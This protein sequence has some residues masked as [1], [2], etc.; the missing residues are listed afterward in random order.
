MHYGQN[1]FQSGTVS[2]ISTDGMMYFFSAAL[3]TAS[4]FAVL[5]IATHLVAKA[6]VGQFFFWLAIVQ[7]GAG[8]TTLGF[9]SSVLRRSYN[10]IFVNYIA[11][12]G[13]GA[14]LTTWV[15][16]SA[17]GLTTGLL[18]AVVAVTWFARSISMLSEARMLAQGAVRRLSVCYLIYAVTLPSSAVILIVTTAAS[19]ESL[20]L[21]YAL[22]E[23][24]IAL[25]G[26]YPIRGSSIR[27]P[28]A[29]VGG[30]MA[31]IRNSMAYGLPIMVAGI[32][33][34]GL[35]SLDRMI[36]TAFRGYEEV[37]EFSILYTIAFAANRFI[38]APANQRIFPLFVRGRDDK[39][40]LRKVNTMSGGAW[41]I[42]I[43]YCVAVTFLGPLA[44]P[45]FLGDAYSFASWDL[46]LISAASSFFLV[47]TINSA[48]LK[49]RND[50][51]Q[52]MFLLF[53]ALTIN[54]VCSLLLVPVL[55][56]RG[57]SISTCLAYASLFVLVRTRV[58]TEFDT[59]KIACGRAL[60]CTWLGGGGCG[61][62]RIA[63]AG[64]YGH[65]NLGDEAL[66]AAAIKLVNVHTNL[67]AENIVILSDDAD[68]TRTRIPANIEVR[69]LKRPLS[70]RFWRLPLVLWDIF[71]ALR[72]CEELVFGGG[73][74]LNDS[75]RSSLPLY[76]IINMLARLRR[77]RV[78][79][80]SI[81]LGPLEDS[82]YRR[83][84]RAI[85]SMSDFV[86][87]RDN[88]SSGL[89]QTLTGQSP[90]LAPDLAHALREERQTQPRT[91]M[92]IGMSIIPYCKPGLWFDKDVVKYRRYINTMSELITG[93]LEYD[94]ELT[95][96][97]MP[98]SLRQDRPAIAD[99]IRTLG[100]DAAKR[101]E[102]CECGSVEE[103]LQE[104]SRCTLIIATRLH[105]A[106]LATIAAT[107]IVAIA[108]QSKVSSYVS[109]LGLGYDC[110]DISS[111][112]SGD[113]LSSISDS[114]KHRQ[115]L[116]GK[117]RALN[118]IRYSKLGK[119]I[120]D[121]RQGR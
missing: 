58:S 76:I 54:V 30:A 49:V 119:M 111:V 96:S 8:I 10:R 71:H 37:A 108:Y 121:W 25:A 44:L 36:V 98:V 103:F 65:G 68:D 114:L 23:L 3:K 20:L 27:L 47:F 69:Q 41:L 28:R 57:A 48:Y 60:P 13:F 120:G 85:L 110:F 115:E 73:G 1:P 81:G 62:L 18:T 40:Q 51:K 22:S 33:N 15:V 26:I 75:N 39:E 34:L 104:S 7:F 106:V 101:V 117:I 31:G 56:Y 100:T 11:G 83:M 16:T 87:V 90:I 12:L 80:W 35:N 118:E 70:G 17:I 97:L 91:D 32:A 2:A 19:H 67:N 84:G 46:L 52:I 45:K 95:V 99:V 82:Q 77:I 88:V 24:T 14:T 38:T 109:E 107:P 105:S 53:A 78:S 64:N 72:G 5:P 61:S 4:L 21:A 93:M 79:W 112:A 113:V 6:E 59:A 74:L 92:R 55:G 89:V 86:S 43:T 50:T 102:A 9:G 94:N 42:G 63:L 66:L 29:R 116:V